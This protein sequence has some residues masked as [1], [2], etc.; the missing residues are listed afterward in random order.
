MSQNMNS[1]SWHYSCLLVVHWCFLWTLVD[2]YQPTATTQT[3]DRNEIIGDRSKWVTIQ[4]FLSSVE[5]GSMCKIKGPLH[6]H[7]GKSKFRGKGEATENQSQLHI[8][9]VC[10]MLKYQWYKT[11]LQSTLRTGGCFSC[12]TGSQKLISILFTRLRGLR[13][14]PEHC[15]NKIYI[16]PSLCEAVGRRLRFPPDFLQYSRQEQRRAI[17]NKYRLWK[18]HAT[19]EEGQCCISLWFWFFFHLVFRSVKEIEGTHSPPIIPNSQ[20]STLTY[21][22]QPPN[23]QLQAS[24]APLL[25]Q[26]G[27][28]PTQ[29]AYLPYCQRQKSI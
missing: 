25:H 14:K 11:V 27:H 7:W 13:V 29:Q 6:N 22:S 19:T 5:G 28:L 9:L 21:Q 23:A 4:I 12:L 2:T 20:D 18:N 17:R 1:T 8:L 24:H 3:P 10:E 26:P 16:F 15:T